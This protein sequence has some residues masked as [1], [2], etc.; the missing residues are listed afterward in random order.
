L[1]FCLGAKAGDRILL[2]PALSAGAIL[3]ESMIEREHG[4]APALFVEDEEEEYAVLR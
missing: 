2:W 1:A 4:E 3:L